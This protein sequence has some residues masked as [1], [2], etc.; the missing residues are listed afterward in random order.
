VTEVLAI[1]S[2]TNGVIL[3]VFFLGTFTRRVG[4]TGAF[5]GIA[6]GTA[7]ML[8]VWLFGHISW[9]WYTLIGSLTTLTAGAV[10]GRA[11]ESGPAK[12]GHHT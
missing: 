12:A 9:Q 6:V 4:E 8:S 3:G 1:A 10:A 2:F 11:I 5:V 7:V